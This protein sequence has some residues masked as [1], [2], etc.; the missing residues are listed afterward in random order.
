MPLLEKLL[1]LAEPTS[2]EESD[3]DDEV[4]EQGNIVAPLSVL[5]P[6]EVLNLDAHALF[7][8]LFIN[9]AAVIVT[10]SVIIADH[11]RNI[12]YNSQSGLG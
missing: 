1:A 4:A 5:A 10:F 2:E 11:R 7:L 3:E 8:E 6:I 9:V 12:F